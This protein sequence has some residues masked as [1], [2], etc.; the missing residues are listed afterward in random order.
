M[1]SGDILKSAWEKEEFSAMVLNVKCKGEFDL[2]INGSR[3][4]HI[5]HNG[6][7]TE[8]LG[9]RMHAESPVV[10]LKSTADGSTVKSFKVDY[11]IL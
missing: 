2:T 3:H 9:F 10:E 6:T 8:R 5:S 4:Y 7:N 11:Y 1:K